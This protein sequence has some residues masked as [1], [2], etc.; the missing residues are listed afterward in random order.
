MVYHTDPRAGF[1]W[2]DFNV[3]WFYQYLD[4]RGEELILKTTENDC[5]LNKKELNER[6][7]MLEKY[8]ERAVNMWIDYAVFSKD[9]RKRIILYKE[10]DLSHFE[11]VYE[12]MYDV[13]LEFIAKYPNY[14]TLRV[15]N[16]EDQ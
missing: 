13:L 9:R 12:V 4:D 14:Y 11:N 15:I 10:I 6:E 7:K 8:I 2:L 16:G 3:A 5:P 1:G